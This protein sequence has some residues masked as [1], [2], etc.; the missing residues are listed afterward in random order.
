MKRPM[1]VAM[2]AP[3]WLP[4]PPLGYGGIEN[5]ITMLVTQLRELDVQVELF[6][7]GE[8]TLRSH[9]KHWLYQHSMYSD[10]QRPYYDSLPILIA[11]LT[12]AL[13]HIK[14]DGSFDIIHD[15]N[16]YIGPAMLAYADTSLP[17]I[18]HTLHGPPLTTPDQIALGIPSNLP[19][20]HELAKSARVHYIP[21][22]QFAR[23]KL[24]RG[25]HRLTLQPVH[26]GIQ[27]SEFPFVTQKEDYFITLARFH[28]NKGQDVAIELCQRDGYHLK[29]AGVVGDMVRPKQVMMELANPLS[30]YRNLIDFRYF[31]DHIFPQIDDRQIEYLGDLAGA[32]K[33]RFISR[34]RALLFPIQWDEPFGMAV[35]EALACGPP[36]IAMARGAMPEIITH[37]YNGFLANNKREFRAYMKRVSEI[38]PA[39]C[40]AS[41]E[42]RFSA[43]RMAEHYLECYRAAIRA[44]LSA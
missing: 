35:V 43:R 17:P 33:L 25:M 30:R 42:Q 40:R 5:V 41:V 10:I 38:D 15:H 9:R 19:M 1:R 34:A 18:V 7:V 23:H 37:G 21:I 2:I 12:A 22:S 16:P 11:H 20:W 24:P 29:M 44:G 28:P 27:A 32:P 31:S 13:N 14:K 3:P 36:V 4:L 6:T 8:S 26:N 39:N